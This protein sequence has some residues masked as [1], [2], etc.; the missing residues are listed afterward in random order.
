MVSAAV[1]NGSSQYTKVVQG[2]RGSLGPGQVTMADIVKS[3]NAIHASATNAPLKVASQPPLY[4]PDGPSASALDHVLHSYVDSNTS[5]SLGAKQ[6]LGMVGLERSIRVISPP[7]PVDAGSVTEPSEQVPQMRQSSAYRLDAFSSVSDGN[8][9]DTE[10]PSTSIPS[11]LPQ[12]LISPLEV[13][14]E[15]PTIQS[16]SESPELSG[17]RPSL[18][19]N[20]YNGRVVTQTLGNEKGVQNESPYL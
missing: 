19:T 1:P 2:S 6:N 14:S 11:S 16:S 3:S 13:S 7:L 12:E 9:V 8:A 20:Q 5:A 18:L 15:G 17:Q 10:I 4:P